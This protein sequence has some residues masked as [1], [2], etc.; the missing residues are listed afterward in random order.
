MS[1][2]VMAVFTLL[3]HIAPAAI[4][5]FTTDPNVVAVGTDFLRI[6]SWN[7]VASGFIFTCSGM[8]QALGN[9]WPALWSGVSRLLMFAIPAV[10]LSTQPGFHLKQLWVLSV[11][12]VCI[13]AVVS[14]WL[15]RTQLTKRLAF[16]P[17]QPA[18]A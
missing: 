11:A 15:V 8:F 1:V 14:F 17:A 18:P 12:T 4:A 2:A 5:A 3:C 6:I 7:F 10:W 16:L 9:T 13:Q